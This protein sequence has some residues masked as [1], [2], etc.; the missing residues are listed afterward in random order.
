MPTGKNKKVVVLMKD[1][2]GGKSMAEFVALRP[3]TYSNLMHDGNS[4]THET[5]VA[6]KATGTKNV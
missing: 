6:K 5:K 4:D 2:L 1:E 3:K